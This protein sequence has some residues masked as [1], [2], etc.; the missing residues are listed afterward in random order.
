MSL[1]IF[2]SSIRAR[3][4][5][6][7]FLAIVL[8]QGAV[9]AVLVWQEAQ[10]YALLKRETLFSIAQ[11]MSA[12]VSQATEAREGGAIR[13]VLRSV[14]R[15]PSILFVGVA[16]TRGKLLADLGA[17]EQLASDIRLSDPMQDV[18]IMALLASRTL[19][20]SVPVIRGGEAVGRLWIISDTKDLPGRIWSA[21]WTSAIGALAA[22]LLAL[23]IAL[24]MQAG[25][26]RPLQ[27]LT[28]AM[29][30]VRES[31]DFA[32]KL[33][34][35]SHD[36][37]GVLVE[38]FNA[39]LG[40]IR[41]RDG[42]LA[43][44]RKNLEQEVAQRTADYREARDQA[45]SANQA[46]SDFLATMSHEIR[47]PMN[48]ILVMADLLA[49]GGL[50]PRSRRYA[51]VI[52]RSG[53]SL[54]AII[55]DILDLSKVEA[56]KLDVETMAVAVSEAAGNACDL[57]AERAASKGLDLA[58]C[59]ETDVAACVSADPVRLNQ[60]LG[61]LVNNALKFTE[62]GAVAIHVARD[63]ARADWI[64]FSV[65][66][67]GIGIPPDRIGAIFSAFSQ[68]DQS[69]T[70][71][72]GGTGLGLTI[73]QR[74]VQAMGGEICVTS[75]LGKG[76][77]F[78][79]SLPVHASADQ[80]GGPQ[81]S[82]SLSWPR[83]AQRQTAFVCVEGEATR[84]AVCH[85]LESAGLDVEVRGANELATIP[86]DAILL[87]ADGAALLAFGLR[88]GG[89]ATRIAAL[90]QLGE[91]S[92][93]LD[94][95]ADVSLEK[96][97][98]RE[99]F[100]TMLQACIDGRALSGSV[101]AK[102]RTGELPDYSGARVLV[103]D[104][105]AVNREV[106]QEA[107]RRFGIEAEFASD[108]MEA[109]QRIRDETFDLVLMDG[110]MPELDGFE[111]TRRLRAHEIASGRTRVCVIA[112]TAHVVGTAA[113]AWREA[114]MDGILHKPF[115]LQ[116]MAGCLANY[117][118]PVQASVAPA[119]IVSQ[120]G[121]PPVSELDSDLPMLDT[122]LIAQLRDMASAGRGDFLGRVT[123]LYQT[124]A[125]ESLAAL[126]SAIAASDSQA[127]A[128]AAHALKSMSMNIGARRVAAEA[129]AM[130]AQSR[131][132]GIVPD[133]QSLAS[134]SDSVRA[135]CDA[136]ASVQAAA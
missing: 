79:F 17:T 72:F 65:T 104:D 75:E 73:S 38:G 108:G 82:S 10:R 74:L 96:P 132:T 115:T 22:M 51:E 125:P 52:S 40:E 13:S 3:L 77:T 101:R 116:S 21:L 94:Q 84:A 78:A 126:R 60:V 58:V 31:H 67:T 6:L 89:K 9:S 71:K 28:S 69:T 23:L 131:E 16:D 111:A 123:Q 36:E 55:N 88:C 46:K 54:V 37:I 57:F 32:V 33:K 64:A 30:R 15:I 26:T 81:N 102:S 44:H 86:A 56:G 34:S 134:L 49:A 100:E 90:E 43:D 85:Y 47:T 83:F 11:I 87:I 53:K 24:R 92:A 114:G 14:G 70:R 133:A 50:P 20:V 29:K 93:G 106:A 42:K 118:I 130:E 127:A 107:L 68:A 128:Q 112:L 80:T 5:V 99:A 12:G 117:L 62:R 48:G 95:L 39:M 120:T 4:L 7:V 121:A 2:S 103:A 109:L 124:H 66:D 98:S 1:A 27:V 45:E 63:R 25:I 110:S 8:A 122:A 105:S 59:V 41:A 35:Q 76:S 119:A 129:A 113:E 136:L 135:A 91:A 18:P 97:L 61:N 19:E